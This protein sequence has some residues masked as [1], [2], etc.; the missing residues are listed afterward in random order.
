MRGAVSSI[1]VLLCGLALG[2]GS[3]NDESATSGGSASSD[4]SADSA[5]ARRPTA[6]AEATSGK[7]VIH[8]LGTLGRHDEQ[9]EALAI[10]E[11]G[12]IIGNRYVELSVSETQTANFGTGFLWTDGKMRD[13][14]TF[15]GVQRPWPPREA[16]EAV[17]INNRG[18]IVGWIYTNHAEH[19]F[20]W[21]NG[22]MID[23]GMLSARADAYSM[24]ADIN[25][26]GEVVGV[27]RARNADHAFRWSRRRLTDLGT[28]GGPNSKPAAVNDRG[29]VAGW[30]DRRC[31]LDREGGVDY[32]ATPVLW[33]DGKR[34]TSAVSA[35]RH[36]AT[37]SRGTGT[38]RPVP[39]RSPSTTMARSLAR[40]R[41]ELSAPA[42]DRRS[43]THS[44]GGPAS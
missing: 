7:W 10:N 39:V 8:D 25:D 30:S 23:L 5:S 32:C 41:R 14:G 17:A 35:E 31:G 44:S 20:L 2:V 24:P 29:E 22:K 38:R 37:S 12:E 1:V 11:R 43:P 6:T 33:K 9:S 15:S 16:S 13:L 19:T 3:T 28:L 21:K 27:S 36:M 18:E 34:S 4:T 26:R 40:A 42:T